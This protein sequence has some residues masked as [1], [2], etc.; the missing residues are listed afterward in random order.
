M[1]GTHFKEHAKGGSI[2]RKF[3]NPDLQEERDKCNF[4][5]REMENLINVPVVREFTAKLSALI[6]KHD[7]KHPV[8][9]VEYTRDEQ[10]RY[11]WQWLAKVKKAA[12]ESLLNDSPYLTPQTWNAGIDPTLLHH[13]MFRTAIYKLGTDEQAAQFMED[14]G[15][16]KRLGCYA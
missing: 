13:G 11:M 4:D 14:I 12:P 7:L 2:S 10:Q 3:V 5:R 9:F 1:E 8:E 6:E 15:S 16:M